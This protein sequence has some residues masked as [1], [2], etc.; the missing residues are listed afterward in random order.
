VVRDDS[1]VAAWRRFEN[2]GAERL[3]IQFRNILRDFGEICC[4]SKILKI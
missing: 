2:M 1:N 4:G 3:G